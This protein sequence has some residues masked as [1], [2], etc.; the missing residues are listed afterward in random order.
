M[1]LLDFLSPE[2]GQRRTRALNEKLGEVLSYYLG[3]TGIPERVNAA[4]M[5]N[6]IQDIYEAGANTRDGNYGAAAVNTA[7][8]LV[9]VAAA[10]LAGGGLV[11][12]AANVISDTLTG[13]G[14]RAQGAMDAGQGFVADEYG[15]LLP[16]NSAEEM[17][18]ALQAKYPGLQVRIGGSPERGYTLNQIVAPERGQGIG[19]AAMTDIADTADAQGATVALTPSK[20]FGGSVPRLKE[21]Y[22]RFGFVPNKGRSRDFEIS[23]DMYRAAQKPRFNT[24]SGDEI[25]DLPDDAMVQ[26]YQGTTRQ[27]AEGI[28]RTGRLQSAGEPSVY[29]TTD[30]GGGGYGDGTVAAVR[31]PRRALEVDDEFPNG[32]MDFRIDLDRPAGSFP[33]ELI[34]IVRK[35]G[36]AGAAIFFGMSEAEVQERM[37]GT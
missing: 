15:A 33:V 27:G 5:M 18:A 16:G 25:L 35:Y 12:D 8:A 10:R 14:V 29:L 9:P 13:V 23:E 36:I 22:G 28:Q 6:P 17:Q 21:F 34:E 20:D 32:R 11:D 7:S 30:P 3:P 31:V 1:G 19:T 4:G 37:N 26:L 2:A 24:L